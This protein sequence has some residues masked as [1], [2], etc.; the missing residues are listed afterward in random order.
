MK[1]LNPQKII[2]LVIAALFIFLPRYAYHTYNPDYYFFPDSFSYI[3]RAIDIVKGKSL[4]HPRRLPLYPIILKSLLPIKEDSVINL[5]VIK[6]NAYIDF[7]PIENMQQYIGIIGSILFSIIILRLFGLGWKFLAMI[8]IFC[9]DI[10]IFG[11]EKNILTESISMNLMIFYLFFL[12][13]FIDSDNPI[14]F[15]LSIIVNNIIFLLK[16]AY[17]LLTM[18]CL[19]LLLYHYFIM[20]KY[21]Y[22]SLII[23]FSLFSVI[24]PLYYLKENKRLYNYDG[25]T[26]VSDYN[27]MGKVIQYELDVSDVHID[28]NYDSI[29]KQCGTSHKSAEDTRKIN[30]CIS[31]LNIQDDIYKIKSNNLMGKFAKTAITKQPFQFISKSILLLPTVFLEMNT[32]WIVIDSISN[33]WQQIWVFLSPIYNFIRII[34]LSFLI[35]FPVN[36]YLFLKRSDKANTIVTLVGTIAFYG[37]IFNTFFSHIEY[38]RLRST[39]EPELLLF[40]FFSITELFILYRSKKIPIS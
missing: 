18:F 16:P 3:D 27:L 1:Q 2:I 8:I 6:Q 31:L 32:G 23:L 13:K 7:K 28:N 17:F 40:C 19:P 25:I 29:L 33:Y 5:N 39:I 36:I 26:V 38:D 12:Y 11:W 37:I 20:K 9:T 30:N 24:L 22:L 10:F 35:F 14:Y 34:T 4:V 21:P 15:L